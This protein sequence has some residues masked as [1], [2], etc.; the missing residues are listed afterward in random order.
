LGTWVIDRLHATLANTTLDLSARITDKPEYVGSTLQIKA[1]GENI[2]NLFGPWVAHPLPSLPYAISTEMDVTEDHLRFENLSVTIGEHEASGTMFLDKPP[3]LS[4]TS[5]QLSLKGPSTNELAGLLGVEHAFLE[6][7]YL[8]TFQLAGTQEALILNNLNVTV[9]ESDLAGQGTFINTTPPT[10]ELD[11]RSEALYLP[12]FNPGLLAEKVTE[13]KPKETS[14]V[15]SSTELSS[16]WLDL[17][18]GKLKYKVERMWASADYTTSIDTEMEL[19]AG[20]LNTTRLQ[21]AGEHSEGSLGLTLSRTDDQ[22]NLKMNTQSSRLPLVWL[23]AGE[24]L[25]SEGTSFNAVFDS[26]GNSVKS[27]MGNLNGAIIFKGGPGKVEAG[28]LENL[29]GD[30]FLSLSRKIV[31][32]TPTAERTWCA[33][34]VAYKLKMACPDSNP[35]LSYKQT[36]L[37]S[38]PAGSLT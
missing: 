35:D 2:E 18:E 3:N 23:F 25:P 32:K 13:E 16:D 19:F 11:L 34:Q 20:E 8:A 27:M 17:A 22:F 26:R 5:G 31:D 10:F 12:L 14:S 33:L 37:A 36:S 1:D 38:T 4:E 28:K 7:D 6:R 30:F 24:A 9:G 21:W 29:F 15:F